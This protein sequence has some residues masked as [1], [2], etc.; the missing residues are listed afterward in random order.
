MDSTW[1]W[2]R[3]NNLLMAW[4]E[5]FRDYRLGE[6]HETETFTGD[7]TPCGDS[8]RRL[9]GLSIFLFVVALIGDVAFARLVGCFV[10]PRFGIAVHFGEDPLFILSELFKP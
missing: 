1:S 5:K 7:T 4:Q 3:L 10:L 6:G 8:S 9:G 2:R